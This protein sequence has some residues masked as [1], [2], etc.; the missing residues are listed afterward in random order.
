MRVILNTRPLIFSKAGI[1]HYI[2]NL[3]VGMSQSEE[4]H[5]I[6]T[7]DTRSLQALGALTRVAGAARRVVG[8]SMLRVTRPLG[9]LLISRAERGKR[10]PEAEIYHEPNYDVIPKGGW[11]AVSNIH[12][13]AFL[14]YPQYLPPEVVMKCRTN[15]D[16]ILSSARFIV[17]TQ[18]V[19]EEVLSLLNL[20]EEAVDVIP[21]A[22]SRPSHEV[23]KTV[24]EG[25]RAVDAFTHGEY[26]LYVGTIEPR[27]NIATLLKAFRILRDRCAV[28]LILAGGK[29]WLNDDLLRM[30]R[31]LGIDGD[32]IFTG[33]VDDATLLFL[34][35]YA[36]VFVYPS[37]YEGFGLPVIEAFSCGV[38]VIA[39]DIPSLREVAGDAAILVD[40]HRHEELAYQ[41]E[42]I[43]LSGGLQAE[44]KNRG[45]VRAATYSWG[46]VVSS[47]VSTYRKALAQ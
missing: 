9:D 43:L 15:L 42:R 40:P 12:D 46:K 2:S 45:L 29:G 11:K 23:D 20:E 19:K 26:I 44:L 13:L 1:G 7:V 4:V 39:S 37:L 14:R 30:P 25:R 33:Y 38:P 24:R 18:A 3:L 8:N 28:K 21:H 6:P 47:T 36:S 16:N 17:H 5:V 35:N 31:A 32:V 22:P 27:K 41:M 34:Y 10:F